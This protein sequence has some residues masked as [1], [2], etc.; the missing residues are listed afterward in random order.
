MS[1]F[2]WHVHHDVLLEHL[3]EPI[4]ARRAYIRDHKPEG[5]LET[6]LRLLKPVRGRLPAPV[7]K[8]RA[9]CDKPWVDYDEARA[10]YVK[11][12]T[13]CM[14]EILRLHAEECPDCPWD[15]ETI[16]PEPGAKA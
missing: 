14:P 10:T 4:E 5:E 9:G 12:W 6:R 1:E 13:T 8:A 15:G 2:Y 16:F 11:A 3:T 7:V